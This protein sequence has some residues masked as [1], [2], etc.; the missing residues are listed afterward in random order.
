VEKHQNMLKSVGWV[1]M[2]KTLALCWQAV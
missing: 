1:G 2:G